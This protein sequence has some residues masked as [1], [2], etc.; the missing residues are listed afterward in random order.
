MGS[1]G[2]TRCTPAQGAR[3]LEDCSLRALLLQVDL[4]RRMPRR[5]AVS[6][7]AAGGSLREGDWG[8]RTPSPLRTD[9]ENL[10]DSFARPNELEDPWSAEGHQQPGVWVNGPGDVRL[11]SFTPLICSARAEKG[12]RSCSGQAAGIGAHRSLLALQ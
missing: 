1:S 4:W 7:T 3:C 11:V 6:L 2:V 5:A 9:A 10:F 12:L 8:A